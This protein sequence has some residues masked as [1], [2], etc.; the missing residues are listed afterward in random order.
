MYKKYNPS[1][2]KDP[3]QPIQDPQAIAR[4]VQSQYEG[5]IDPNELGDVEDHWEFDDQSWLA[6]DRDGDS[7]GNI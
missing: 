1:I 3:L 6:R 2:L 5:E 4:E 7:Q